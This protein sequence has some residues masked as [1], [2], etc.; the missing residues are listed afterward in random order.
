RPSKNAS[1]RGDRDC[2]VPGSNVRKQSRGIFLGCCA[3]AVS[4]HATTAPLRSVINSRRFISAPGRPR[5]LEQGIVPTDTTV[6][7]GGHPKSASGE[8]RTCAVHA[9]MCAQAMR[10]NKLVLI[11]SAHRHE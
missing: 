9:P 1:N 5:R 10:Y 8:S 4:G 11:R 2:S 3:R 7:E 6:L